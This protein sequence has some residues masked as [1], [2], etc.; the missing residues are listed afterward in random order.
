MIHFVRCWL[1]LS[2]VTFIVIETKKAPEGCFRA[3]VLDHVHQTDVRQ[4]SNT[5]KIIDLNFKV[6]EDAAALAKKQGADIIVFPENGLIYSI[7]SREKADEFASDIPDTE[8]NAC[9]LDSKAVYNR[10]SCLAQKHEMFV[11]ADLIDRK[12]CDELG[13][14]STS[15]SCPADKRFLFNTAVLFDRQ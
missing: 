6:Y 7:L 5:A 14:S 15:D 4:F 12:S 13:I 9:T 11:V 2:L 3:A 1:L 8:M 10:L